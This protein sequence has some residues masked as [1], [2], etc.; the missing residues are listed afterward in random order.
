MEKQK[1]D[2]TPMGKLPAL[3]IKTQINYSPHVVI[4]G[5]GA[6]RAALPHGDTTGRRLPLMKDFVET[7]GLDSLLTNY[8]FE[9]DISDFEAFFD[10]LFISGNNPK[11]VEEIGKAVY[12]YFS[13]MVLPEKPTIY[14][15]LLLS[16]RKT[17]IIATFNW[18][19]FLAQ[20]YRR[21]M[22]IAEPPRMCFLHGNVGI[23]VCVEHRRVGFRDQVCSECGGFLKPSKLLYPVR[24]KD[25]QSDSFI[26]NEWEVFRDHLKRAYFVTIFGY[27]AP[28]TDIEARSL[29]L[30]V[31]K[32]NPTIDFAQID[33]IDIRQE[34]EL[35]RVWRDFVVRQN[36]GIGKDIFDT[37]LFNHPRRSCE[38]LAMA[39]LQQS[40]WKDNH[41]P[42]FKRLEELHQWI[43]P[44]LKEEIQEYFTGNPCPSLR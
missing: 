11:M 14:D 6:S 36:Y 21:N 24:Q 5:A 19:P 31:W 4:L 22:H 10:D 39:S 29:M 17:D 38:A 13:D 8:G 12:N 26:A 15:Y 25:Y 7:V 44:L 33:I 16:L 20:A 43:Q 27:S 40:P 3:D 42:Q 1:K 41:W 34:S 35:E 2:S 9:P 28:V 32:D 18:D 23:G 30:E 37:Y